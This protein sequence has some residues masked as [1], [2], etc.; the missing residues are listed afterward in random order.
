MVASPPGGRTSRWL[1]SAATALVVLG[2]LTVVLWQVHLPLL[3][4]STT[5]TGGDTGSHYMM[6]A[7]FNTNLFPHLTGWNPYWYDGYPDYTFYF[8]LPDV[9]VALAAHV[10]SYDIAFKLATIAGSL[11]L[12]VAAWA[13]GRL[14]G[15]RPPIPAA[16][17]AATLPFLFD[18]TWTIYGGNLFSTLAGEYPYSFSVAFLVLFLGL[19]ARGVRTGRYRVLSALTLAI[20]FLAH[21][22]PGAF[23]VAGAAVL[24]VLELLPARLRPRDDDAFTSPRHSPRHAE[25]AQGTSGSAAVG[26]RARRATLWWAVST[27]GI[28][29]LLVSW[30]LVPFV[31]DLT[32]STS[33]NYSKVTTYMSIFFPRADLWALVLA[34]VGAVAAVVL[35]SRVGI[36]LVALAAVAAAAV[37]L[38]PLRSLYNVRF[39]PLWFLCVYLL[40]GWSFGVAV[41]ALARRAR[42]ARLAR[43]SRELA[44]ARARLA[45]VAPAGEDGSGGDGDARP[46]IDATTIHRRPPR[47]ARWA[48]GAVGGACL[49]LVGALV[50][51]VPPFVPALASSLP[52]VGIHPGPNQVS[53]W[54]NWNYTGYEGKADYPEYHGLMALMSRIGRRYGCGRA[55]WEYNANENRFGTPEALM[56]LPLWTKGCIDSMEGLLFESSATT[57]YHF[58]NQAELSASPSEA[59][60]GLPYG[61]MT[62]RLGVEHLQLLGV[63]YFMAASPQVEQEAAADPTLR[64]LATSGPWRTTY[65]GSPLT[66]TWKIYL[67]A[68][69]TQV[70]A[71]SAKPAVLRGV[72]QTQTT[73]LGKLTPQNVIRQG[74]SLRWYLDPSAWRT[75]LVAGGPAGWPRIQASRA[76][77]PPAIAQRPTTV[78]HVRETADTVSFSVS[79]LGK[80]VLVKTSYFPNW[81]ARGA[82]GPWR[83]TPNLMVVVPTSHHVTLYYGS[84]TATALGDAV[85]LAGFAALVWLAGW[86]LWQRRRRRARI[87]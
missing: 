20:C 54:A 56:L 17:A 52:R 21:A 64:L 71:L 28:G 16:L 81:H 78:S 75:E 9:L 59:V 15:L 66:T 63:R 43:S 74:P 8:V 25:S 22:V 33:M 46:Q 10:I 62:V 12:P 29:M 3:L 38:D 31:M 34:A 51:V 53:V 30:W 24:T 79:R 48:P 4:S 60:V 50:A 35:R 84:S 13:F 47:V 69:S 86:T 76:T 61:P 85:T 57:P 11:L 41:A 82:D 67:V 1:P 58:L 19:F 80:P 27:V 45:S 6:P 26:T 44:G 37:V 23:A 49:A 5:T 70:T 40:V 65:D 87:G 14:F 7:Y 39:L 72:G 55:M 83:A 73:W 2:V 36:V 77:D 42:H 32:Y 18:Y 68:H